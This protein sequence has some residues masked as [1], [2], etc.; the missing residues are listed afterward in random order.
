MNREQLWNAAEKA[1]TRK[2]SVVAKEIEIALPIDISDVKKVTLAREFTK[3]LVD[4]YNCAVDLAVHAP[5]LD[6]DHRNYHAHILMT[7]RQMQDRAIGPKWRQLDQPEGKGR[8]EVKELRK[9]FEI[10]QNKILEE[11]GSR[12]RVFSGRAQEEDRPKKYR[13]LPFRKYQVLRR[14]DRLEDFKQVSQVEEF[15][16]WKSRKD[17]NIK[18]L[19]EQIEQLK[20]K[21]EHRREDY[22]SDGI[23]PGTDPGSVTDTG[24]SQTSEEEIEA[25][26]YR[27]ESDKETGQSQEVFK[28]RCGQSDRGSGESHDS[29]YE[30]SYEEFDLKLKF[31]LEELRA[32]FQR[33][34]DQAIGNLQRRSDEVQQFFS[35]RITVNADTDQQISE[36]TER[37]KQNTGTYRQ[38]VKTDNRGR[39]W[40]W[41]FNNQIF[42]RIRRAIGRIGWKLGF[43]NNRVAKQNRDINDLCNKQSNRRIAEQVRGRLRGVIIEPQEEIEERPLVEELEKCVGFKEEAPTVELLKETKF[44]TRR[45]KRQKAL[46]EQR[47]IE[48]SKKISLSSPKENKKQDRGR[49]IS[50]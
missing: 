36:S 14:T 5:D 22:G 19:V 25:V 48:A 17:L 35:Q 21:E 30:Y 20:N 29:G 33:Q 24:D 2:N 41:I 15:N 4:R 28:G 31:D 42:R 32:G 18:D 34:R 7:S 12:E 39:V 8:I 44:L 40:Q 45:E 6:S 16:R 3:Y 38:S 50:W 37:T 9:Q 47:A 49:G 1:E 46:K 27:R 11:E 10:F 13:A 43:T 26:G 23:K